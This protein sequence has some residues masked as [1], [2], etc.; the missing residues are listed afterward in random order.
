M[1][2]QAAASLVDGL[3]Y[4]EC[5][6]WH[7]GALWISDQ[8]AGTVGQVDRAGRHTVVVEVPGRPAGLGWRPDGT[9]LVVSMDDHVLLAFDHGQL[10][11]VADLSCLH[12]GPSNDMV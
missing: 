4:P 8:H 10:R 11:P 7:D 12:P 2:E 6:R 3:V 1:I 9:L 5:P